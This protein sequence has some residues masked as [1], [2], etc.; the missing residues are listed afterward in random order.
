MLAEAEQALEN[1]EPSVALKLTLRALEAGF[2]NS[3][4]HADAAVLLFELGRPEEAEASARR[5]HQ[6]APGAD[7]VRAAW[8]ELGLAD[9]SDSV[10]GDRLTESVAPPPRSPRA[11]LFDLA[12]SRLALQRASCAVT[13]GWLTRDEQESL[14]QA[15]A[16]GPAFTASRALA[17]A[18]GGLHWAAWR[19]G[20][21]PWFDAM[22]DDLYAC[23]LDLANAMQ[24]DLGTDARFPPICQPALPHVDRAVR[25]RLNGGAVYPERRDPGDRSTFPLRAVVALG[26][27]RVNL[28][29]VDVRPG[30]RRERV[31]EVPAGSAVWFCTRAR[32]AVVGGVLGLQSV[33]FELRGGGDAALVL[34]SWGDVV[35]T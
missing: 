9:P 27:A 24:V 6:L 34:T 28:V 8:R 35:A 3:R 26:P 11:S 1:G 31:V 14:A 22:L 12:A 23:A 7:F 18:V 19:A 29:T 5:A 2:M 10:S 15:P 25:L 16:D 4:V 17:S 13:T 30:K 33:A 21:L 20:A 32:P